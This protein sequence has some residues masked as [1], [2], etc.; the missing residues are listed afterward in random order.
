MIRENEALLNRL[1]IVTDLAVLFLSMGFSY[2]VRFYIFDAAVDT[3]LQLSYY[4]LFV[5]ALLPVYYLIFSSFDLISVFRAR[6]FSEEVV[7]LVQA[8]TVMAGIVTA[9]LFVLKWHYLSRWVMV[10][11]FFIGTLL[12]VGKHFLMRWLMHYLREKGYHKK[13]LVILGSGDSAREYLET[14]RSREDYVYDYLGYVSDHA[15]LDGTHLGDYSALYGIL[16]ERKPE[17]LI[18]ALDLSEAGYLEQIMSDCEKT[19]TKVSIIPFC[20]RYIP[21]RPYIDQIDRIPLINIRKIPLDNYANAFFKRAMDFLGSL[22]LLIL[23]SPIL[24]VTAIG[25]K[26]TSPGP[27]IFRQDRV[28]LNKEQFTMYKFRSMVVN[29]QSNI[30]WSTNQDPR[31]TKF[32]AFIRKF[33]IDELPQLYNVLKGDMSLV[34]PRPELPYFVE[35]FQKSVPLY[36]VKHQVKPGITGLAQVKGYRGD[37]SIP[38]RIE[39]DVYYI[40]N[41]SLFLDIKILFMTVFK[42]LRN[43]E[44]LP[45]VE[46][47]KK[48]K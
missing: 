16:N 6:S 23:T 19:G 41:W 17:E 7:K 24:L 14:I 33:S 44:A 5:L 31:K 46:E 3:Y 21:S 35:N 47:K 8:N 32:G 40:E 27:V 12:L 15:Q 2:I 37:T 38:K 1:N 18:C 11:Y 43:E 10:Q 42:G 13:T 34:G 30:A 4:L 45:G 48:E 39:W 29:D 20:Y 25:V 36:M 26:L 28:G 22:F 9:V